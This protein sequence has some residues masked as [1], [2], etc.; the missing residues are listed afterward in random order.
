MIAINAIGSSPVSSTGNGA[1]LPREPNA[2]AAP[3]TVISGTDVTINWAAPAYDGGS[4]IIGYT[5]LIR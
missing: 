3:I 4:P 1:E 2:P 5:V